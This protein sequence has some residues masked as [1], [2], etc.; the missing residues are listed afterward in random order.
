MSDRTLRRGFKQL[1]G[2]TVVG[3]LTQQRIEQAEQTL[4]MGNCTVAEV[5]NRV[6]YAHLGHFAA[7]FKRHFG[8]TPSQCLQ[9]N[10]QTV[11]T[12][13]LVREVFG[14]DCRIVDDSVASMS[15]CIPIGRK[16]TANTHL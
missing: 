11:M 9:G 12:E 2:M 10:P 6:G 4:R 15:L 7:A 8:I 14:L 3:Y 1:F 5:A 13:A 16:V